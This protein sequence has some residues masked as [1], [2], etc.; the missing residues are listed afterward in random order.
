MPGLDVAS[1]GE[2]PLLRLPRGPIRPPG[3]RP[4]RRWT[5][6]PAPPYAAHQDGQRRL[7]G[8]RWV[9]GSSWRRAPMRGGS[10]PR[11][12]ITA[13][14]SPEPSSSRVGSTRCR[15]GRPSD[16]SPSQRRSD[17]G[18]H[19]LALTLAVIWLAPPPVVRAQQR[20]DD[21]EHA[22]LAKA[23]KD[24]KVSLPSALQASA[25]E[26]KPISA[27]YEVEHDHLQLSVY[28]MKGD[29]FSEVIV[30]HTTGKVAKV[31]PLTSAE[32]L[33]AAKAQAEAMAKAKRSLAAAASEAVKANKGYRAVSVVP[34]LKDGHPVAEVT[35]VKGAEWKAVTEKRSEE[36]RVGKECRSRWSPYH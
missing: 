33:T 16:L 29:K 5:G 23:L 9:H 27:K 8:G 12:R 20:Y 1:P 25:R 21:K 24:A 13:D 7:D 32:D 22:E 30:D 31:D 3:S 26:G 34:A 35:L 14:R 19:V 18:R 4:G 11:S 36:R 2:D 17:M 15:S 10:G 28:T 6:A